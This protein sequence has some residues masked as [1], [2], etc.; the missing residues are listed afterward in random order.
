M[1]KI[2]DAEKFMNNKHTE[3]EEQSVCVR[4][5]V[6]ASV[7]ALCVGVC[8]RKYVMLVALLAWLICLTIYFPAGQIRKEAAAATASH[9]SPSPTAPPPFALFA[10][11]LSLCPRVVFA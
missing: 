8:V 6:G 2:S 9:P 7:F 10:C 3:Q 11:A 1:H 4:V 5:C